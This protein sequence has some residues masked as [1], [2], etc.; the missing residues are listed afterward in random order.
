M[1]ECPLCRGCNSG[2]QIHSVIAASLGDATHAVLI[3]LVAVIEIALG[4]ADGGA[5]DIIYYY[6]T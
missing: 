2:R 1:L 5:E 6:T 4:N 3:I